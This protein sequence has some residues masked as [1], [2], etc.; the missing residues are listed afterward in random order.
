MKLNVRNILLPV[1]FTLVLLGT[2]CSESVVHDGDKLQGK[3]P[4]AFGAQLTRA[5]MPTGHGA[6]D[7]R[8]AVDADGTNMGDFSVWGG[9]S[10]YENILFNN[11]KV[12]P[13]GVYEGGNRYWTVGKVHNFYALHPYMQTGV[14]CTNDTITVS[15]FTTEKTGAVAIDLMTASAT[16]ITVEAGKTPDPVPLKFSHELARVKFSLKSASAITIT[17]AKVYGF[18][19]QGTLT[20]KLPDGTSIWN[21]LVNCT[22]ESTPY[23][24]VVF[25][26]ATTTPHDLFGDLLLIPTTDLTT[27]KL[28]VTYHYATATDI[29]ITAEMSLDTELISAWE[30]GNS[31]NYEATLKGQTIVL[32]VTIKPWERQDTSVDW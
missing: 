7:S 16:G 25:D 28:E 23:T 15:G 31:Y 11:E 21:S 20:K 32:V 18:P 5:A 3:L 2:A 22:K 9:Y 6:A 1:A 17:N 24:S 8:A 14:S 10:D 29:G 30:A 19:Y 4:I 13:T 27:A 12:Y 26:L